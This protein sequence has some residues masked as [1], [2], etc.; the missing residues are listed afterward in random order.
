[1]PIYE[2]ICTECKNEQESLVRTS[3]DSPVCENCGGASL[4]RKLSVFAA[5]SGTTRPDACG[6]GSGC[7]MQEGAGSC[8]CR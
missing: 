2:Y 5:H 4:K 7:M 6:N 1:M 8:C 3:T